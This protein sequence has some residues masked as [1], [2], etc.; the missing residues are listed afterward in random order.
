MP[1]QREPWAIAALALCGLSL[2]GIPGTA[3]FISK[4]YLIDAAL[5]EGLLG[6]G[7]VAVIAVSSVLA[8]AYVWRVFEACYF[9]VPA[10]KA[11]GCLQRRLCCW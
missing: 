9:R 2:I 11:A 10:T 1:G 3:G 4:W 6:A 5:D 8:V 7:L